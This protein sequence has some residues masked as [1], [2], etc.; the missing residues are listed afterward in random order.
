[1]ETSSK[2]IVNPRLTKK[3][4]TYYN[5][6]KMTMALDI[7]MVVTAIGNAN[8]EIKRQ[9]NDAKKYHAALLLNIPL[10][11]LSG[12]IGELFGQHLAALC[13]TIRK[14]RH[15]AG[16]PDFLPVVDSSKPWFDTPTQKYYSLGGFDTKASFGKKR[17][18]VSVA[19]SSHHN[20]TNTV[21][22][23]QWAYDINGVPEII[24][25][26][27]TNELTKHDWKLT[28]GKVNSKTTN[29]AMLTASGKDKLRRGW[30]V[31]DKSV[32]LPTR[33]NIREQYGL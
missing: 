29:A 6:G 21:L 23:V 25:I 27:F 20:Q 4:L 7:A 22:V 19:A 16:A 28:V 30:I 12:A 13:E 9:F 33:K 32:V 3:Q 24:G 10:K 1:V 17:Q 14:N 11:N 5:V 18:F 31:L 2:Y 26:F 8:K 15:E